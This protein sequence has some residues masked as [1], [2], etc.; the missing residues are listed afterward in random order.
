MELRGKN[1]LLTGGA[2]GIG[3][4]AVQ[5]FLDA[6]ATVCVFDIAAAALSDLRDR[7]P[8]ITTV[9]CDVSNV[10]EVETA[11]RAYC[12]ARGPIDI[13][14]NNAALVHTEPLIGVN[15][16]GFAHHS[17]ASWDRVVATNLNGVFYVT[18]SAI[19]VMTAH[20]VHGLIVNVSSIAAAGNA[21][22]SVY[23]ATKAA[24][25][26]LTVCWA[27]ELSAF[28][29]RTVGIAPGFA[30]TDTTVLSMNES[31]LADW[32]KRTPVRRLAEPDE[33]VDGLFFV[34]ANDFY[35][36]RVLELDGGL[37]L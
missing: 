10:G 21:G 18:A 2:G 26:A 24:L 37:R 1:V 33:I 17:V 16:G 29:I 12:D 23:S 7:F 14:I 20:R 22:Q 25:N 6:D 34:I 27:K 5:R 19:R 28:G 35:N 4:R 15:A 9:H 8:R 31:R 36:G 13:L 30:R 32:T 11:V 3:R